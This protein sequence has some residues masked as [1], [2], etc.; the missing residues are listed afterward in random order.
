M[1]EIETACINQLKNIQEEATK[2]RHE[3][4]HKFA[5]EFSVAIAKQKEKDQVTLQRAIE[6]LK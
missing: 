6:H 5:T 2:A 4:W 1:A 3:F